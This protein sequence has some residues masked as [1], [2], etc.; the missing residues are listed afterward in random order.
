MFNLTRRMQILAVF[1]CSFLG[2]AQAVSASDLLQDYWTVEEFQ[3]LHPEEVAKSVNFNSRV[4]KPVR[5]VVDVGKVIKIVMVL[6][7]LQV[8][9]YWRRSIVAMEQRLSEYGVSYELKTHFTRPGVVFR[10]QRKKLTEFLSG[11]PD[12]V[13][14]TLNADQHRVLIKQLIKHETAKVILQ[15]ITT[16]L[17]TFRNK[18]PFLY[19]GFD[20]I[21]GTELLAKQY[22]NR[23]KK[24]TSF[25]IM[26]GERGYVSAMRCGR[27]QEIMVE[28]AHMHL[29]ATYHVGFNRHKAYLAT[30]DLIKT[31]KNLDFIYS[32]S[33]DIAF[34][35]VDAL[36]ETGKL[37]QVIT[38]GWGGGG[39]ELQ[40]IQKGELEFTVMRM[41]D[42]NG[43]AMADAIVLHS[44]DNDDELPTIYS[45][46][47]IIVDQ[48]IN[49]HRLLELRERAFRYSE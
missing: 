1:L 18:Q 12:Y 19:V 6:P 13:V 24:E 38:N 7:G 31:N 30:K 41:N 23:F 21:F 2:V 11:D 20:H 33:T 37:G 22:L 36:K 17:K 42:D 14:F 27:F 3:A 8:S 45:G 44:T 15:N 10:E 46:S 35:V 48:D 43:V 25:A 40:A 47:M 39:S 9:D 29:V 32:C 5:R 28:Q 34:G 26:Y 16:P 49:Q 4:Q